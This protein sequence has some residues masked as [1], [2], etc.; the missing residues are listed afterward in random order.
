MQVARPTALA[1]L[2]AHQWD[3]QVKVITGIRRCGKSYLLMTLFREHLIAQ[4]F[5]PQNI[6]ALELDVASSIP[7]R[8]PLALLDYFKARV[9]DTQQRYIIFIDEIQLCRAVPDPFNAHGAPITFYDAINEL[10]L[11]RHVDVYVTGSNSALLASDILSVF[12]GRSDQIRLH[13]LSFAEFYSAVGGDRHDCLEAYLRFGGMPFLLQLQSP[14]DKEAYLRDL[15]ATTY[16]RDL[17]ERYAIEREEVLEG[18]LDMLSSSVGSLTNPSRVAH[19]MTAAGC[20][21][22]AKLV[23]RYIDCLK[24]AFLF[25]EHKRYSIKGRAYFDYPSKYYCEDLG[26]RNAR[27]GFRQ[28]ES[29]HLMENLVCN[30]LLAR[31]YAVDVGVV[32]ER[33]RNPQGQSIRIQREIDFVVNRADRRFYIQSAWAL[34]SEDKRS[35]ELRPLSLTGD[36]FQK[37]IIRHDTGHPWHDD[38]GFLHLSLLDFLLDESLL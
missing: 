6:L 17:I 5:P 12:R 7:Y 27:L 26:L 22:T 34:P 14:R 33:T 2:V 29:T 31:G 9:A 20:P 4:G 16:L 15:F 19:L 11:M 18:L 24:D 30:E 8:N 13:P 3:G 32:E 23:R 38:N 37:V 10:R 25:S 21:A 28:Q 35:Q 36:S 1:A